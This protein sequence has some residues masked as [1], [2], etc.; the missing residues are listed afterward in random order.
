MGSLV[1]KLFIK[2]KK[3]VSVKF[4]LEN[5]LQQNKL[6]LSHVGWYC[7]Y[8]NDTNVPISLGISTFFSFFPFLDQFKGAT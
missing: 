5:I 7:L 8:I 6:F 2:K 1:K 4:S 3:N